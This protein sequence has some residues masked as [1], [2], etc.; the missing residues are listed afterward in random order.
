MSLQHRLLELGMDD[1]MVNDLERMAEEYDFDKTALLPEALI[2]YTMAEDD[3]YSQVIKEEHCKQQAKTLLRLIA[4]A[5]I[6]KE[7]DQ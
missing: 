4:E 5:P 6:A 3:E 2:L 1:K 7:T